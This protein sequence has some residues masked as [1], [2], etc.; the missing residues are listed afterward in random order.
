MAAAAPKKIARLFFMAFPGSR[1]GFLLRSAILYS[2]VIKNL[3]RGIRRTIRSETCAN[4][5][6]EAPQPDL[7]GTG[8]L[9]T[10]KCRRPAG[11]WARAAGPG[12]HGVIRRA[13]GISEGKSC[14]KPPLRRQCL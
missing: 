6:G 4:R 12:P 11:A 7:K 10:P 14:Q 5:I 2:G 8:L 1:G 9:R 13:V 3:L